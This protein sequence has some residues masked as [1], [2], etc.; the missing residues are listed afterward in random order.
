MRH[1]IEVAEQELE[2]VLSG[3]KLEGHLVR[4]AEIGNFPNLET[5][6]SRFDIEEVER[7]VNER[8]QATPD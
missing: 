3:R 8:L 7:L 4:L 1:V 6:P 5:D 2:R